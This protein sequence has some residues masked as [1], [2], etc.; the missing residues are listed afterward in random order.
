MKPTILL[1]ASVVLAAFAV[2]GCKETRAPQSGVPA[3]LA[4]NGLEE[5]ASVY[6]FMAENKEPVPRKL[7]DLSEHNAALPS[8]WGKIES[9]E[10]IVLWGAGYSSSGNVLAYEKKAPESGGLVLLQNGTVKE[11]TAAEFRSAAKAR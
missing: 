9:G 8:A 6:K 3:H 11:M 2:A 7:E 4:D 1:C 5:L 10:Y